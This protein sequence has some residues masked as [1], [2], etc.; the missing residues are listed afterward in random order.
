MLQVLPLDLNF[1]NRKSAIAVYLIP[2]T[3]G[4]ILIESGPGSTVE[5][6]VGRLKAYGITP[7]DISDV[8]LTHIHLDHAGAAGWLAKHGARIHVHPIGAPHLANPEKLLASAR[9]IYGDRMDSLWGEFLP[10]PK[11][12]IVEAGDG[13]QYLLDDYNLTALYTPGHAEH[14]IAWLVDDYCFSGDIGGVRIPGFNYVRLPLVP[15]ELN[16]EKWSHSLEL[17]LKKDFNYIAP[18]HFGI[19]TDPKLHLKNALR[20]VKESEDW[21]IGTIKGNEKIEELRVD[22]TQFLDNQGRKAGL[23]ESE[24][25]TYEIA[26]PPWMGAD[27]IY[28]LWKWLNGR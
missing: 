23:S 18:T 1:N 3:K 5:I 24:L 4:G 14:H 7:E 9:R 19:F 6:L 22:Y 15:P 12:K 17:L 16:F 21:M 11:E 25:A 28:R 26:N 2:T 8:F 27:G 13:E 10:V 20:M